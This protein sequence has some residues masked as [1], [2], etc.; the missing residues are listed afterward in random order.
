MGDTPRQGL[1]LSS[2]HGENKAR[3]VPGP[4]QSASAETKAFPGQ[5]QYQAPHNVSNQLIPEQ[6]LRDT[7]APAR[8]QFGRM[9]EDVRL[10][11]AAEDP[12]LYDLEPHWERPQ[13]HCHRAFVGA[14]MSSRMSQNQ[15]SAWTSAII[16][17][18]TAAAGIKLST[19]DAVFTLRD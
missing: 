4:P 3:R 1:S 5:I 14:S 2:S 16:V 12:T 9:R 18:H 10:S 11:Q 8:A 17:Y 19:Q 7:H 13:P 15:P 6:P